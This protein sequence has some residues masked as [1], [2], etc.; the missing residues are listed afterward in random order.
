MTEA[1]RKRTFIAL[2]LAPAIVV[3]LAVVVSGISFVVG[4]ENDRF[5]TC[6]DFSVAGSAEPDNCAKSGS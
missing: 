1:T 2:L 5:L 3:V 6:A 4:R